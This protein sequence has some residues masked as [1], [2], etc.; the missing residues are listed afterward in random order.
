[1]TTK[2]TAPTVVGEVAGVVAVGQ[3]P[4]QRHRDRCHNPQVT[5][6]KENSRFFFLFFFSDFLVRKKH[7]FYQNLKE[8]DSFSTLS[9]CKFDRQ[10]I[11]PSVI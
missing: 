1:M 3:L 11:R 9:K 4:L 7:R 8:L 6:H 2:T 5:A 10:Y